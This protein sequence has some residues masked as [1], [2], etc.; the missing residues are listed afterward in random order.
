MSLHKH[1]IACLVLLA[2]VFPLAASAQTAAFASIQAPDNSNFPVIKFFLDVHDSEGDFVRGLEPE[3]ISISENGNPLPITEIKETT[4]GVQFVVSINPGP[5]LAIRNSKAI[6]RFDTILELLSSWAKSRV[7]SNIDDLSLVINN[8]PDI[9]HVSDSR[10]WLERLETTDIDA[11]KAIPNLDGLFRAVTIANDPTPRPGMERVVLFITPALEA[12]DL[13]PLDNLIMQ[14]QQQDVKVHILMVSSTGSLQTASV[15]RLMDLSAQTGGSFFAY[16][17]EE[18]LPD[19]EQYLRKYRYIYEVTYRSALVTSGEHQLSVKV[20]TPDGV[21][22][23]NSQQIVLDIQPPLPAF[24]AP[25]IEI[26]RQAPAENKEQAATRSNSSAEKQPAVYQPAQQTLQVV[27]DFPDGRKRSI[28]NSALIVD[29]VKVAENT[30]PPFDTFVWN[31]SAIETSGTHILQAQAVDEYG[32]SGASIEFPVAIKIKGVAQNRWAFLLENTPILIGLGIIVSG[33][34]LLLVLLLG[35][36]LRPKALRI[37]QSRLYKVDVLTQP[38]LSAEELEKETHRLSW[39][40]RL[41]RPQKN[42]QQKAYALLSVLSENNL[43]VDSAPVAITTPEL[44]I[45][46]DANW[47]GL[48]LQD[49]TVE[50]RHARLVRKPDGNFRLFDEGSISGTWINYTPV[51]QNGADLE[52]GDI[53]HIGK[54]CYRFNLRTPLHARH[55]IVTSPAEQRLVDIPGMY[56]K[57]GKPAAEDKEVNN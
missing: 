24:I 23:S 54:T 9:S 5:S 30:A 43:V 7:G 48:L 19:P 39:A 36:R 55:P 56:A 57:T 20:D 25:P 6:S 13:D 27:F 22:E 42:V 29:G 38:V 28:V 12:K 40:N 4:P 16:S 17:G 21:L 10:Q 18:T 41:Q 50:K 11:R 51:S 46:T 53:I 47:A 49:A 31:I 8:S 26:L 1:L 35:G 44:T 3:K 34:I 33:S 32:L 37:S 2:I 14:A 15:K 52:H 45:G